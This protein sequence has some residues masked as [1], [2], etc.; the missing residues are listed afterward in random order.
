MLEYAPKPQ[1]M[2]Q[3]IARLKLIPAFLDQAK[4]NLADAPEIWNTVAVE[5]NEGNIG[6]IDKELRAGAAAELKAD[7]DSAATGALAALRGFNDYLKNDLAKRTSDWRLGKEK[8]ALKFRYNLATDKTP[9]QVLNEAEEMLAE[10]RKEMFN[11]ALPLHHKMYP[12][13][14]DPV[15]LNLI[16]GETLDKIAQR[17]A[18]P[19]TY[20][21]GRQ[22]R[23]GRGAAVRQGDRQPA[24]ASGAGQPAGDS[25]AGVHAR[26][27]RG[28]RIQSGAARWSRNW[29]RSTGSRRF[30]RTGPRRA[31]SRNCGNTTSMG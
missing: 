23:S 1:R 17:H 7:Y 13:H 4:K 27:L 5:E 30:R 26:H 28:G 3:I 20:F 10:T 12:S 14:R 29:A 21:Y 18:T 8:Y 24:G 25:D 2:R 15:D 9:E 11:V 31:S 19:A 22:A 16:V 6:L